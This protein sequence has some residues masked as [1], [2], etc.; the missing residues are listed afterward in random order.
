M[1]DRP[2]GPT[3]R[4][5]ALAA[6]VRGED[7]A[8]VTR[9]LAIAA[10][11]AAAGEAPLEKCRAALTELY[12]PGALPSLWQRLAADIRDGRFDAAGRARESVLG[13]L[14]SVTLQKLRESNPDHLAAAE[15]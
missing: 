2:D 13:L 4:A 8:L 5:L 3:L 12:G 10:R 1:R 14:W 9:A 6:A 7:E 11:E 15:D